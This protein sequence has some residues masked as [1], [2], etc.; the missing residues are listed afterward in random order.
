MIKG[1]VFDMDNT[2]YGYGLCCGREMERIN[3]EQDQRRI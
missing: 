1:E 2:V 3:A